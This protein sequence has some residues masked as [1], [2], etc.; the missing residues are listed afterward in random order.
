[1]QTDFCDILEKYNFCKEKSRL[2]E[3]VK[4]SQGARRHEND[5]IQLIFKLLGFLKTFHKAPHKKKF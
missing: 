3:L 4:T 5:G 1:M 2:R